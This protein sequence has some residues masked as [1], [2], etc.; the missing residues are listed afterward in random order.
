MYICVKLFKGKFCP[1]KQDLPL[2]IDICQLD[3]NIR[4]E[5]EIRQSH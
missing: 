1:V 3:Q 2:S 5:R 4:F